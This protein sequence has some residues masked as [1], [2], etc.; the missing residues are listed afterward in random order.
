LRRLPDEEEPELL[1]WFTACLLLS[2]VV[3]AAF[4]LFGDISSPPKARLVALPTEPA[5]SVVT[6][7]SACRSAPGRNA[8]RAEIGRTALVVGK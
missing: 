5:A 8:C 2:A 3:V 4:L 6:A 1:G 7:T